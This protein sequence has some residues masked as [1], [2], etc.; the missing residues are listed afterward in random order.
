MTD[1]PLELQRHF[2]GLRDLD[3]RVTA[4]QKVIDEDCLA[5]LKNAAERQQEAMVSPSKRQK[6]AAAGAAASTELAQRIEH[7]MNETI[8]LSEEKMNR[9]QQIY[10]YIDQHIRKLDK[11][12]KSFEA[13]VAKERQRLGLPAVPGT[14]GELG[15]PSGVDGRRKR[16]GKGGAATPA[17]VHVPT[18]EELYHAALA[19][20]DA[21][22]P[23][24]CYCNRISFGE[25]IACDNVEC[26]IEWF[27]FECVGLTPEN[28][29]KGECLENSLFFKLSRLMCSYLSQIVLFE[30]AGKWHCKECKKLLGKK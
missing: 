28:R 3:L 11:D 5:Q 22:E 18:S 26:P 21:T 16:G 27:H 23:T 9:A 29:P 15:G 19:V 2:Q 17:P 13:E 30:F 24:Y 1:L 8:K 6:V 12:L 10:D 14:E 20:A 25:M 4:L 7:N